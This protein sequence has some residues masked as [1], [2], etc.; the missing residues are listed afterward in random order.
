MSTSFINPDDIGFPLE[1][2]EEQRVASHFHPRPS[3]PLTVHWSDVSSFT[4]C[5]RQWEY[6]SHLRMGLQSRKLYAPFFV[7]S[8]VHF[9]MEHK[10]ATGIHPED[11]LDEFE[12]KQIMKMTQGGGRDALWDEER[13]VVETNIE[14]AKG[15]VRHHGI[16]EKAY[17]GEF[18]N[19]EID[20]IANERV[21]R[22]PLLR[23]NGT[24]EPGVFVEGRMDGL[25]KHLPTNEFWVYELKTARSIHER[26]RL[27]DNDG[28]ATMY[29]DAAERLWGERISGVLFEIMRKSLPKEPK[30]LQDG[31]LSRN[32]RI[33]TSFEM[34]LKCIR[35]QHP[36]ASRKFI[37][38]HYGEI[39]AHLR[40]AK[41]DAYFVRIPV[42]RTR[43]E[44]INFRAE[45]YAKA[46][47]MVSPTTAIWSSPGYHCG[48]CAFKEPCVI[49]NQTRLTA[50]E[51]PQLS[52]ADVG[53]EEKMVLEAT[54][55]R[56]DMQEAYWD[57]LE[58]EMEM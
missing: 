18:C 22:L 52:A 16:W 17:K 47:Q 13:E 39:L 5:P 36:K 55:Q 6:Q 25:I 32:I 20:F 48:F 3:D 21:F 31:T 8:A 34:Y 9:A 57:A 4:K 30:V 2:G 26:L 27:L 29:V 33:D 35:R 37:L 38:E 12:E 23:P 54:Y 40:N 45:L 58:A 43:N 42:R 7:G 56:R 10:R 44:V 53:E 15:L 49:R 24:E 14:F 50:F 51:E 1:A 46:M 19:S 41:D 11:S 28:Q